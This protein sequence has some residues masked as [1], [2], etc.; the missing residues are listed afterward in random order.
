ME[1]T[2]L[3]LAY[4]KPNKYNIIRRVNLVYG[5]KKIINELKKL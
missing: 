4:K 3:R 2:D 1:I 5:K